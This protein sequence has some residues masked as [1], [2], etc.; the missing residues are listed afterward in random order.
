MVLFVL[1]YNGHFFCIAIVKD[2]FTN[3]RIDY[4]QPKIRL[5]KEKNIKNKLQHYHSKHHE[6]R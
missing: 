6:I 2:D 1:K 4:M 3:P 5:L